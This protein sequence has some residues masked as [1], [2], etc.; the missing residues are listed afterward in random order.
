MRDKP[1]DIPLYR[2]CY[3]VIQVDEINHH[4]YE[5]GYRHAQK[6]NATSA[7]TQCCRTFLTPWANQKL[8]VAVGHNSK[9][10]SKN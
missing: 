5:N 9:H 6:T 8:L 3:T 4:Q 10:S 7:L 2:L 1:V